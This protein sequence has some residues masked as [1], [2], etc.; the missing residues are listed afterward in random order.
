[1][2]NKRK[3][4]FKLV[5]LNVLLF[6]FNILLAQSLF[7]INLLR[8]Q[9]NEAIQKQIISNKELQVKLA[10]LDSVDYIQAKARKSGLRF[11][12]QIVYINDSIL[13]KSN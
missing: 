13:T 9:T 3:N 8:Y 7:N 6:F 10:K 12:N 4:Y 2:E 5:V 1:M 11:L